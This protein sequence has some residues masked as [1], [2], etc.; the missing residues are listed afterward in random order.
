M[1]LLALLCRRAHTLSRSLL[2]PF[3]FAQSGIGEQA[4]GWLE[5]IELGKNLV[6]DAPWE[7]QVAKEMG[8]A[9]G[10]LGKKEKEY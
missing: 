8:T 4:T 3:L 7:L 9:A 2:P 6:V 1:P 5:A 10:L